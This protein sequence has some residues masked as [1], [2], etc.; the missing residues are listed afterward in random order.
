[1]TTEGAKEIICRIS[2]Q[3]STMLLKLAYSR[4]Q[5]VEDA[6]DCVQEVLLTLLEKQPRFKSPEHEKA[7]LIRVTVNQAANMRKK[8]A[9]RFL[10]LEE[11]ADQEAPEDSSILF[12]VRQLPDK[13]AV[14]IHL[15]YYEGYTLKE[16]SKLLG[17]PVP[18]VGTRLARAKAKLRKILKGDFDGLE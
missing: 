8:T 13:Y 14:V 6:E 3:Y 10:P 5:S 9:G 7:W 12:A 18:T 2:G 11:A 17:L 16:I 4:L 15:H 1:M